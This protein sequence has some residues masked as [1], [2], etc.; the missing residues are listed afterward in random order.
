MVEK[1]P[2]DNTEPASAPNAEKAPWEDAGSE[3]AA[4]KEADYGSMGWGDVALKAAENVG[5]SA[6]KFGQDVVQP[7]LHPIETA[8]SLYNVGMGAA[9]KLVPGYEGSHEKYADAV[10]QYLKD[11]YATNAGFK[12]AVAEDPVGVMS[13]VSMALTGAGGI[14]ARAPGI[15]GRAGQ[16]AG[17]VGRAVDPLLA[18]VN[19]ARVGI[20]AVGEL[21]THTGARPLETAYRSGVEGGEA[22]QAFREN[23]RGQE[24]ISNVVDV[25]RKGVSSIAERRSQKYLTDMA[26]LGK[27]PDVL[28]WDKVVDAVNKNALVKTF[29]GV[30]IS[31]ATKEIR[32][33]ITKHIDQWGELP[34]EIYHTP[35]GF[36]ALKQMIGDIKDSQP[37]GSP[38][39]KVAND[40]YSAIR[41]T[42]VDAAPE[43]AKTM[44]NY[45][46]A[47]DLI[48]E[49]NQTLSLKPGA[50]I[51]TSLRKLQSIMRNNVNTNYGRRIELGELLEANGA[52]N[53]LTKLSGQALNAWFPRGLGKL[54]MEMGLLAAGG[55]FA[56]PWT[57][58]AAPFMSP[59][60]MGEAAHATGRFIGR[61]L[62]KTGEALGNIPTLTNRGAGNALYRTGRFADQ[63]PL[64]RTLAEDEKDQGNP[65]PATA[66][67]AKGGVVADRKADASIRML[68]Q[69]RAKPRPKIKKK[70]FASG[71]SVKALRVAT[72]S[73]ADGGMPGGDTTDFYSGDV[74]PA[75]GED[76]ADREAKANL[77]AQG[78]SP[79]TW[80]DTWQGIK[81]FPS[82]LATHDPNAPPSETFPILDQS[83][84]VNAFGNLVRGGAEAM[85][86]G[87][88]WAGRGLSGE[89]PMWQED[90]A[91]GEVHT[92]PEAVQGAFD[93]A[94]MFP[95][96]GITAGAEVAAARAPAIRIRP[97]QLLS[98]TGEAAPIAA[99][100]HAQPAPRF[101]SGVEK[102]IGEI[103]VEAAPANQW[104]KEIWEPESRRT[105]A[106]RDEK[107]N[108]P[109]GE[110]KEVIT[111]SRPLIPGMTKAELEHTGTVEWL[112]AKGDQPVSKAE[113][114]Q[115]V[116]QNKLEL[117]QVVKRQARPWDELTSEEQWKW[118]DDNELTP[119]AGRELYEGALAEGEVGRE[120]SPTKFSQYQ[121]PGGENYKEKLLT[122][123]EKP[124]PNAVRLKDIAA[125]REQ[126][127][128]EFNRLY[129]GDD[130]PSIIDARR[131]LSEE[132]DRL[133]AE[134]SALIRSERDNPPPN[135][136]SSH[137]DE[138][139][140]LVHTRANEREINGVPS[141]HI[142]EIQSDWHQKGRKQGYRGE[143][144]TKM[145]ELVKQRD[146]IGKELHDLGP[147]ATYTPEYGKR[148]DE[149]SA[150]RDQI[151]E[152]G[153]SDVGV[154][155]APFKSNWHELA[156][157]DALADAVAA[158]KTRISWTPGEAQAARYDLSKQ[159][160]RIDYE[161]TGEGLYEVHA[162]DHGGKRVMEE[163][164]IPISRVEELVGKE[165]AKKI[166]DDVG[167]KTGGAYRDW[168]TMSG[169]DLKVGGEFHKKL[170]D[171]KVPQVLNKIGKPFG[172]KVEK[173]A[174]PSGNIRK[175][176]DDRYTVVGDGRTFDTL[177]EAQ[178]VADHPVHY[179]DIPPAL[180]DKILKEGFSLFED[181]SAGAPVA[182]AAHTGQA[183][184][185][186]YKATEGATHAAEAVQATAP[187]K[188]AG[189]VGGGLAGTLGGG[190][191]V[192]AA[193]LQA[194]RR[195][196][197]R[198]P[199]PGLPTKEQIVD[200]ELFTPGPV[201]RAHDVADRYMAGKD[202]GV[203]PPDKYYPINEKHAR[204]I[205]KAFDEMEHAPNDPKVKAAYEA[206]ARET[207]DQYRAIK[208]SGLEITPVN[209]ADYPYHGNPR[210]VVKDVADNNHMAFF[211]TREGFGSGEA[212]DAA[213]HP[214]LKSSGEKVGDYDMLYNDLFRVVH[215]YFGHVKN[216]YGFRAAGEDNAWRAHAAM[217]SPEA[218]RAMTTETRGQNSWLNYGP[219]GER[220][221]TAN[222]ADTIYA[223]QKI[224][225][226]P[227]W[228]MYEDSSAGA[229]LAAAEHALTDQR[230][231]AI[232]G[233][234][235]SKASR[236]ALDTIA[237]GPK[238]AGPLDLASMN[239]I[240][241]VPQQAM[242]RYVPARGVSPRL[243]EAL[244]NP[245]IKK[246]IQ[247]SIATGIKMGADKWYHNEPIRRAF[248]EEM[249]PEQGQKAFTK[250]ADMVSATSP[251]S[252][253]PTNIRNASYYYLHA[254]NG[255]PLPKNLVYP[256][257]HVA[258]NLHRQNFETLTAPHAGNLSAAVL[259]ARTAWDIFKNPKPASFS[260]NL[261]GN[262]EPGTMDTHA[263]RNIGM[264]TGDPRFLE[265]S[266][267]QVY[268]PGEPGEASMAKRF[269]EIDINKGGKN[270]VTYR[271]QK[272]VEQGKLAM[273]EAKDIP[274]F[275]TSKPNENEYAAAETLY[276]DLGKKAGIP[277]AD[278]QA[279]AWSGAGEL[280]GLGTVATHTFPELF[281][282]RVLYTAIMRNEDPKKTLQFF[283]RG[284]KP[285][286]SLA[287][288]GIVG[289]VL[290]SG[291]DNTPQRKRGGKVQRRFVPALQIAYAMRAGR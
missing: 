90:P 291:S 6:V 44:K 268:K 106:V 173:G 161:R 157:K 231:Q 21:G 181:T 18:P 282:E 234:D 175:T 189:D 8:K 226:L 140:V 193:Q 38:Q 59:R 77:A 22:G 286:L 127:Q 52:K 178:A 105:V 69:M 55:H 180:K 76:W 163:D 138:P 122:L 36:D 142:E 134:R 40:A 116:T 194:Q 121:L 25:A 88:T 154:P 11:R 251:R 201:A 256:Y 179:M 281:N 111:P 214:L 93:A 14:A 257:G 119:Q 238:G 83:N 150:L 94:S 67:F 82:R 12:K 244:Q 185:A 24:P 117:G 192:R 147:N 182:A 240:P 225:L 205:A 148:I 64:S 250:F 39:R 26:A 202:F 188:A 133:M 102:A 258:Q 283:I 56:S 183:P 249:G 107:T 229:P 199:L 51:D 144:E 159:I 5:P 53:L 277:T 43:Y 75:A 172:A 164:E 146:A 152:L 10:G 126:I 259:E 63:G 123:P 197:D 235:Y 65:Q 264:R 280:T 48:K 243:S 2:W 54:G 137:W 279:A 242:E 168:R 169:L 19:A 289:T 60:L 191:G 97:Q 17:T 204:A 61:P 224:G 230:G 58:A 252:D 28:P 218:R 156:I 233:K 217:Y 41:Q 220:N 184:K 275:W 149:M 129:G 78:E 209:A 85:K 112:A 68:R 276:R 222:A 118:I 92:S 162:Y 266:L 269:G 267:T 216:G 160:S 135:F 155:S 213:T 1:A 151:R 241:N 265:T 273:E 37:Y 3:T 74:L 29:Q 86:S 145:A 210:A 153:S 114:L 108:K 99:A 124:N 290:M 198:P 263:F 70:E 208:E 195:A 71:G 143:Q 104:L 35:A 260:Q 120:L 16:V 49:M 91:T 42:I 84:I 50:N 98:D 246:G 9:E 187:G 228:V 80:A 47:S 278:A 274:T 62:Q 139:N 79:R 13:D 32:D 72:D 212:A 130:S 287:G 110:T 103:P 176:V 115:H 203:Q 255:A 245:E 261:Q 253:V 284:Q 200:G 89:M 223:D 20:K 23:M 101:Y 254:L 248:I 167:E 66:G 190:P 141:H 45:E 128:D 211:K 219:H 236:E 288:L 34:P 31:P 196:A 237:K 270:I 113:L 95:G 177:A 239:E 170:Y 158:G 136:R 227:D 171:Q 4:P 46:Q 165:I 247:Q 174:S 81:E 7:V 57:L 100:E 73:F 131:A 285:L 272:L 87:A 206:M 132:N 207:L 27:I 215:D 125:R 33:Q 109:T 15:I 221:R 271:P 232:K 186:T 30:D 262:L 166:E 96:A